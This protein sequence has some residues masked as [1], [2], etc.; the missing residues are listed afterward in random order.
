MVK[1]LQ[2]SPRPGLGPFEFARQQ[3]NAQWNEN[4]RRAGKENHHDACGEADTTENSDDDFA[5]Q[6][7]GFVK[8]ECASQ[9][10]HL[11]VRQSMDHDARK[12]R[13]KIAGRKGDK[14]VAFQLKHR[15]D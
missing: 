14:K 11:F 9:L 2:D 1:S 4:K 8:P 12:V 5:R 10:V 15:C 13:A 3:Q 6:W 7:M